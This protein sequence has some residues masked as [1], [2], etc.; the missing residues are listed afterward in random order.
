MTSPYE[1]VSVHTDSG[2]GGVESQGSP[3]RGAH[4]G[5]LF[6]AGCCII[7]STNDNNIFKRGLNIG[8]N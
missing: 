3:S 4:E 5:H 1:E 6:L 8:R 2:R 7:V